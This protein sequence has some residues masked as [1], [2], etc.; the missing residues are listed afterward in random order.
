M[1]ATEDALG[2]AA[3]RKQ[4]HS[5]RKKDHKVRERREVKGESREGSIDRGKR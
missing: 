3:V 4:R 1:A 5:E 2:S